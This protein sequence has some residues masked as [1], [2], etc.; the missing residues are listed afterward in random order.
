MFFLV[1]LFQELVQKRKQEVAQ[2]A[3]LIAAQPKLPPPKQKSGGPP[4][5]KRT[6]NNYALT[7]THS[8][9]NV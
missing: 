3:E 2:M 7:L 1:V 6:T 8:E 9:A 5:G 4:P